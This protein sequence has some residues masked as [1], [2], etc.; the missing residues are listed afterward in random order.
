MSRHESAASLPDRFA[1][2]HAHR[3]VVMAI[4]CFA[5]TPTDFEFAIGHAIALGDDTDTLAAITGALVGAFVGVGA[6]PAARVAQLEEQ[7][8]GGKYIAELAVKLHANHAG[9][10]Q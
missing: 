1:G 7:G 3:S 2:C 6:L 8:K 5:A 10:T 9:S 4:A